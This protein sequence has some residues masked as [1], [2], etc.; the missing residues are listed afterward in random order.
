MRENS[1]SLRRKK[2]K[3]EKKNNEVKLKQFDKNLLSQAASRMRRL[4]ARTVLIRGFDS[5]DTFF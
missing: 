4:G 1:L 3:S 2:N 5:M